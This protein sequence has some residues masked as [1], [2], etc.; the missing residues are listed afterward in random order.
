MARTRD[1]RLWG[2]GVLAL[3][4]L[5]AGG[6]LTGASP[7]NVSE[8]GVQPAVAVLAP[9]VDAAVLPARVVDE[10]RAAGSATPA[11]AL[12]VGAVLAS[13]LGLPTLLRRTSPAP[14]SGR[15]PLR[16]RRHTIA[17]RAPPPRFRPT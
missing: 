17:L 7:A 14:G 2:L 10:V 5:A 11:R 8:G 13:L 12:V 15:E 4:L 1:L 6:N 3:C 9:T 16:T